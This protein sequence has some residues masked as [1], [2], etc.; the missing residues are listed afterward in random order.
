[1]ARA[2]KDA[3]ETRALDEDELLGATRKEDPV[4]EC[5]ILVH[6]GDDL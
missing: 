1:M 4:D 6:R 2:R 3:Q 5:L